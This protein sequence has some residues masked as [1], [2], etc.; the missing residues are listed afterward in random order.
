[1]EAI[2]KLELITG[3]RPLGGISMNG[4]DTDLAAEILGVAI[5][6]LAVAVARWIAKSAGRGLPSSRNYHC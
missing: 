5:V 2:A 4:I 3:R 6:L 1:V